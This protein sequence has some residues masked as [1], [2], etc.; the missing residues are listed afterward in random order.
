MSK[1]KMKRKVRHH[2]MLGKMYLERAAQMTRPF[3][4]ESYQSFAAEEFARADKY[5]HAAANAWQ[6]AKSP[7]NNQGR[8]RG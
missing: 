2:N 6:K 3:E 4:V 7:T 5:A 8:Q 1:T